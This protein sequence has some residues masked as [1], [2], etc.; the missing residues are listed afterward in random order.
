MRSSAMRFGQK[1]SQAGQGTIFEKELSMEAKGQIVD[2]NCPM[3]V[4]TICGHE[5]SHEGQGTRFGHECPVVYVPAAGVFPGNDTLGYLNTYIVKFINFHGF[6]PSL[7]K[8][9]SLIF[10]A[11][12]N[13]KTRPQRQHGLRYNTACTRARTKMRN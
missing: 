12:R 11:S 4:Q 5:L 3:K 2:T 8:L 6:D 13:E 7:A 1:L 10:E 9:S